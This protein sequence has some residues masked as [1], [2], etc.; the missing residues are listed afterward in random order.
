MAKVVLL[1]PMAG[2]NFHVAAGDVCIVSDEQ[3]ARWISENIA[4]D[5]LSTEPTELQT[6]RAHD[7]SPAPEQTPEQPQPEAVEHNATP[8]PSKRK[9]S[10]AV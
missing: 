6:M 8:K 5:L 4:R 1:T 10:D 2:D 7:F 3:K 9:K